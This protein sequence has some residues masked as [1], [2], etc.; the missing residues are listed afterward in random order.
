M[1]DDLLL[2][3]M[4]FEAR[5]FKQYSE[6]IR[7]TALKQGSV[8]FSLNFSDE[9]LLV[10]CLEP[11]V[12]V[13]NNLDPEDQGLILYFQDIDSHRE[14]ISFDTVTKSEEAVFQHGSE[15]EFKHIFE[16]ER[17]LDE[18]MK[19]AIRRKNLLK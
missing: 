13:G 14:G 11:V 6:P 8:Y 19:C 1:D 18:L 3:P 12:F 7:A 15:S 5:E 17:G 9:D 4:Q 16:Y 2:P 10:P